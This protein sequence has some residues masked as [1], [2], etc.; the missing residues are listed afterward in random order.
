MN[1]KPQYTFL[2]CPIV[3]NDDHTRKLDFVW[4]G[5]GFVLL[6]GTNDE[7]DVTE[8]TIDNAISHSVVEAVL[9]GDHWRICG[10]VTGTTPEPEQKQET[11]RDRPPLL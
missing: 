10:T 3:F 9:E 11:W 8:R 5:D 6:S 4:T 1:D 7:I 2:G